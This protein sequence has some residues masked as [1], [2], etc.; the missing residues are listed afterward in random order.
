MTS[1]RGS[2]TLRRRRLGTE[3][4]RLREAAGLTVDQVAERLEC[5]A[6]KISPI[7]TGQSRISCSP[8]ANALRPEESV[9]MIDRLAKEW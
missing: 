1:R 2:P 8:R 3:L 9:T 5:S 6:S 4:R 7:E